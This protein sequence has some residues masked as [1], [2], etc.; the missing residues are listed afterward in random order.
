MITGLHWTMTS[1]LGPSVVG[2]LDA[3][4]GIYGRLMINSF[5]VSCEQRQV[6]KAWGLYLAASVMDHSWLLDHV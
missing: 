4:V 5:E 6:A 3:F 1:L 2:S